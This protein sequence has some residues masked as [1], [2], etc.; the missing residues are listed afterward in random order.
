MN[1]IRILWFLLLLLSLF[2]VST[3]II[4]KLNSIQELADN[5]IG[6][7]KAF[8]RHGLKLLY[9]LSHN[10]EIDQNNVMRLVEPNQR[11]NIYP[12]DRVYG[13]HLYRNNEGFLPS[14]ALYFTVGNLNPNS[15]PG[16]QNLPNFVTED[17]NNNWFDQNSNRDR[18]IVQL[19]GYQNNANGV[20]RVYISEHYDEQHTYEI[21][22]QLLREI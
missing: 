3:S 21:S 9:W 16:S 5:N 19:Y 18:V 12:S 13:F 17:Y 11:A 1:N 10:L 6:F 15:Y 20:I 22:L 14:G 8:P 7:G 4:R 2:T